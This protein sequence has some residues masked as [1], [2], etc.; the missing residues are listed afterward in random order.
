MDRSVHRPLTAAFRQVEG[1]F[2]P[3]RCTW[4]APHA[5]QPGYAFRRCRPSR[6]ERSFDFRRCAPCAQDDKMPA[7]CAASAQDDKRGG[8][9]A[10][11]AQDDKAV[12]ADGHTCPSAL[13]RRLST[14][15][16]PMTEPA[17]KPPKAHPPACPLAPACRGRAQPEASRTKPAPIASGPAWPQA[18]RQRQARRSRDPHATAICG[19]FVRRTRRWTNHKKQGRW[20][21][22]SIGP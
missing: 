6:P 20:A 11:C 12:A 17:A 3:G 10:P 9:F 16:N 8:R 2:Q 14:G 13:G 18:A 19:G 4:E 22:M 21:D 5:S 15:L 7:A 1:A